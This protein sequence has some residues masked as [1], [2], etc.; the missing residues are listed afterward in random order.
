M[1]WLVTGANGFLGRQVVDRFLNAGDSVTALVRPATDVSGLDWDDRVE[2]FRG[3]L[4]KCPNLRDAFDGVDGLVHLAAAVKGSPEEQFASAV[5][6]TEKLLT[7]MSSSPVKR[8]IFISSFSVYDWSKV[9]GAL[10]ESV[11]LES[12][13]LY[14]RD[15]YAIA[16]T[17]Q[18]R[19]VRRFADE[20]G[21]DLTV[22]RPGFIWGRGNEW[23]VGLGDLIGK[24]HVVI[25]PRRRLPLTHVINCADCIVATAHSKSAIGETFNV[26]D[27]GTPNAWQLAG[28]YL[29]RSGEPGYRVPVP[30]HLGLAA[31]AIARSISRLR[32]GASGRLPGVLV[33]R[34]YVARFKSSRFSNARLREQLGWR[35]PLTYRECL[36]QTYSENETE[37]PDQARSPEAVCA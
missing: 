11:P 20:H 2:L 21:W 34:R 17:W 32:Y 29:A 4:R 8:L 24:R 28:D 6:A 35:P 26:V 5:V 13:R 33:P 1:K 12:K 10:D 18:E 16:K 7:A 3:D 36:E 37:T 30:Y 15:G 27:D 14:E 9:G 23:C 25:G 22:L 31:A 19:V